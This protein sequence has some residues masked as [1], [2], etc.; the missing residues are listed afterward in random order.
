VAVYAPV[1]LENMLLMPAEIS[2]L[3]VD[4]TPEVCA[5]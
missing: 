2:E 1:M 5:L 3:T 4:D